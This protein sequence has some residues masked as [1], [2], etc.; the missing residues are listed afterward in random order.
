MNKIAKISFFIAIFIAAFTYFYS[1]TPYIGD[2]YDD[3]VYVGL[4]KDIAA[5]RGYVRGLVP[6]DPPASKYPPG[7][8]L[9]LSVVWFFSSDFPANA[10]GFK[11]VTVLFSLG[12]AIVVFYWLLW[13]GESLGKSWVIAV[14][15]LFHP[16]VFQYGTSV[17]SEIPFAFFSV[18]AIWAVERYM[19]VQQVRWRDA[20]FPVVAVAF[21]LYMR[22]FGLA[23]V[24]SVVLFLL[25]HKK[26]RRQGGYFGVLALV[27]ILPLLIY[28]LSLSHAV[29][30]YGQE[31]LLKSIEQPELGRANLMDFVARII[32]NTHSVLLAGLPGMILPSQI[33]L[34]HINMREALRVGAPVPLLDDLLA[35]LTITAVLVPIV[36]RRNLLD[37]Y[38][39]IYLGMI[40]VWPW[41]PTRFLVPLV[42]LLYLYAFSFFEKFDLFRL[43]KK[44]ELKI[45]VKRVLFAFVAVF[46]VFNVIGQYKYGRGARIAETPK[47]WRARQRVFDWIEKN[48]SKDDVLASM[49]DYQLYL[50]ANRQAIRP[51]GDMSIIKRY[52][53]DYVVLIPYGGVMVNTDLSRLKFEQLYSVAPERF[54]LVYMDRE[55]SVEVYAVDV[56]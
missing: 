56:E 23:L 12:L 11:A 54:S 1:L 7:W 50:Y 17:F 51:F 3:S 43:F 55:A 32:R 24:L 38:V 29:G 44:N 15:T 34:T 9:I 53:I 36:L 39:A 26:H 30:D 10:V 14:L 4:S 47:I 18:L 21:S 45:V 13:R 28:F 8:P 42:P 25:I 6:G 37:W 19:A 52:G 31:L 46:I 27:L 48:T 22:M 33:S 20:V 35:V 2:G 49:S 16:Y 41:E 5:G 40:L